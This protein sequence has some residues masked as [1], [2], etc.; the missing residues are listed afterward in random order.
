MLDAV[1]VF[2]LGQVRQHCA[3]LLRCFSGRLVG[4]QEDSGLRRT[5]LDQVLDQRL[6]T[7]SLVCPLEL[8]TTD[9]L[10][11]F[12]TSPSFPQVDRI[13]NVQIFSLTLFINP[14]LC[15]DVQAKSPA[16]HDDGGD[17]RLQNECSEGVDS[18]NQRITLY[19]QTS[20]NLEP[21]TETWEHSDMD[22]QHQHIS[23]VYLKFI[24][25]FIH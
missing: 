25:F 8:C 16:V 9:L 22:H 20:S 11:I 2:S 6:W 23:H 15:Y 19:R 1:V 24:H 5:I 4:G 14:H 18:K 13:I 12:S 7:P 21:G 10:L 3:V 17:D